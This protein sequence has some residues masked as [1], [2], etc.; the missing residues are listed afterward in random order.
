MGGQLSS[1]TKAVGEEYTWSCTL[2]N[3]NNFDVPKGVFVKEIAT[4]KLVDIGGLRAKDA[5]QIQFGP[6]TEKEP[7]KFTRFY[8]I[9]CQINENEFCPIGSKFG[10]V[11]EAIKK[12]SVKEMNNK[13]YTRVKVL[14]NFSAC[15][16]STEYIVAK[17]K[18]LDIDESN[19][20]QY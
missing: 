18:E 5:D 11:C 2:V 15:E 8:Q 17:L 1:I 4:G 9:V 10:F 7:G 12:L 3:Q 16:K 6:Y 19:I 20:H 14:K 13:V